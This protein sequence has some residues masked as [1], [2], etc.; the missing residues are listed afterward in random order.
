MKKRILVLGA[1]GLL[2]KPVSFALQNAGYEVR[3]FTRDQQK[4]QAF[5]D[6][7][8]EI[9]AGDLLDCAELKNAM[10][11]C[12]GVHIGLPSEVEQKAVELVAAA[13]DNLGVKRIT[14]ISGASVAEENRAFPM[15]ERKLLAEKA[16][17][18][19]GVPYSILCPTWVMESLPMFVNDGKAN[20]LGKQPCPYHWVAAEDIA[21]MIVNAYTEDKDQSER[22]IVHGPQAI[23]MLDALKRYCAIFHPQIKSISSMPIWLARV[24]AGLMND[25]AFK[26]AV[27]MMAYFEKVGEGTM[28]PQPGCRLGEP[29]ITLDEWMKKRKTMQM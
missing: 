21:T 8:F 26:F 27:Q 23:L 28:L 18:D 11:D 4:A 16:I 6:D 20:G 25:A 17:T 12:Y 13:A 7:S 22:C 3:V 5:F 14:Y 29:K 10:Q 2:G 15:I 19:S 24:L 9:V 1:T